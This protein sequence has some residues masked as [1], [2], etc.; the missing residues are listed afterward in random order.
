VHVLDETIY[1]AGYETNTYTREIAPMVRQ[2]GQRILDDGKARVAAAG[3]PVDALLLECLDLRT[4]EI[5]HAHADAWNADL[6]VLGTHG[7]RGVSRV[8]LGSDAEQ[9]GAHR[10]PTRA[11]GPSRGTERAKQGGM[12][13]PRLL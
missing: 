3:V 9:M 11:A 2:G 5:V 7:R 12:R 1:L 4:A 10:T 6:I 8:L 13:L